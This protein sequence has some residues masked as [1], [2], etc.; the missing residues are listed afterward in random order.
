MSPARRIIACLDV[1]CGRVVKGVRFRDL[2]V[3]G[4]PAEAA[5]EYE[6]QARRGREQQLIEVAALDICDG[7]KAGV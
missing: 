3:V 7:G 5:A 4:E 2:R 6:G 1:D